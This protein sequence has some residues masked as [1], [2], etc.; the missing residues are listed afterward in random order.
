[1]SGFA[2]LKSE[3]YGVMTCTQK[4]HYYPFFLRRI[5]MDIYL[6]V[7]KMNLT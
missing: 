7:I 2:K 4:N 3:G 6:I 1:M 5:C